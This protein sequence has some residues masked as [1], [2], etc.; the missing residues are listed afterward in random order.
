MMMPTVQKSPM[1]KSAKEHL[2]HAPF[3]ICPMCLTAWNDRESFVT[4]PQLVVNGYQAFF[5]R[6]EDG[7]ILFTHRTKNCHS[8]L[9]LKA[10]NF[11][12]LYQ[13]PKHDLLNRGEPS[14]PRYCLVNENL[15]PCREKCSMHW[16]RE[17]LQ[18]LRVH[19]VS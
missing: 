7:L 13:G 6:P 15:E 14:C 9:A 18:L 1:A 16:V 4:D 19:R 8:T 10:A 5:D 11:K 17:V 2:E 12:S 3:K